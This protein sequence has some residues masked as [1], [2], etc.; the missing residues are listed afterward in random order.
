MANMEF[1]RANYLNT[2]TMITVDSGSD[3]SYALFDHKPTE[4]FTT[5][6]DNSDLTTCTIRIEFT[7]AKNIDRIVLQNINWKGFRFYYNSN[8]ANTF[9]FDS[10]CPTT[11]SEW[12]QNSATSLFLK[13]AAT[14]TCTII[15]FEITTTAIANAEKYCGEMWF[16]EKLLQLDHN[17]TAK[18]YK[19]K[20]GR[21]EYNHEMSDGATA[22]YYIQDNFSADIKLNYVDSDEYENI[23]DIHDLN[24]AFTFVPEPT[25]TAW[26]NKIYDVN[27]I[28]DFDFE[29]YATNVKDNGY[30]GTIRLR[31]TPK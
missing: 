3:S 13:P 8:T 12:N 27:W 6:G 19:V 24:T 14:T 30:N 11:T 26:N 1:L 15:T 10:T 28:G 17:P 18:D 21:K 9:T 16:S 5:S 31:E 7:S 29:Q 22:V 2:T 23:K 25:G 20:I 4:Y